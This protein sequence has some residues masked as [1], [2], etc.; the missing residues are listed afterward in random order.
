MSAGRRARKGLAISRIATLDGRLVPLNIDA[1][2]AQLACLLTDGPGFMGRAIGPG[3]RHRVVTAHSIAVEHATAQFHRA[4]LVAMQICR[5]APSNRRLPGFRSPFAGPVL[6]RYARR[7]SAETLETD[8]ARL[9]AALLLKIIAADRFFLGLTDGR[10]VT[11]D[12]RTHA[13]FACWSR[14]PVAT[15]AF[16]A[17]ML[18]RETTTLWTEIEAMAQ[19]L[20]DRPSGP[21]YPSAFSYEGLDFACMLE[22][23]APSSEIGSLLRKL[24]R[25]GRR[26]RFGVVACE[27]P[28]HEASGLINE[29][30]SFGLTI[31]DVRALEPDPSSFERGGCPPRMLEMAGRDLLMGPGFRRRQAGPI[32]FE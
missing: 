3:S 27:A 19:G 26:P 4:L 1:L 8:G 6:Q 5:R 30:L 15:L 17:R 24:G 29:M 21:S 16:V 12:G 18:A 11:A 13:L 9:L 23:H 31:S 22:A 10:F 7:A 32:A 25:V 2:P 14:L 28:F 20:D